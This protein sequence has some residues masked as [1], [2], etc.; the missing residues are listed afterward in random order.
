[1]SR[2]TGIIIIITSLIQKIIQPSSLCR[3]RW[4]VKTGRMNTNAKKSMEMMLHRIRVFLFF[5][6]TYAR[7]AATTTFENKYSPAGNPSSF[8]PKNQSSQLI[9]NIKRVPD[10][11]RAR[12]KTR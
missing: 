3:F 9:M 1:M 7:S 11:T 2:I 8:I 10:A 4:F 12:N 5:T 6:N